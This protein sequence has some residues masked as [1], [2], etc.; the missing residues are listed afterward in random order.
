MDMF[1]VLFAIPR[2]SG[3][4]A[5]GRK[6]STIPIRRSGGHARCA[7]EQG[8]GASCRSNSAG[9]SINMA[10]ALDGEPLHTLT[11][12]RRMSKRHPSA[13]PDHRA[14]LRPRP[15]LD[16]LFD[17]F[18]GHQHPCDRYAAHKPHAARFSGIFTTKGRTDCSILPFMGPAHRLTLLSVVANATSCR[19]SRVSACCSFAD[20]VSSFLRLLVVYGSA[21][22]PRPPRSSG[23]LLIRPGRW[24][25]CPTIP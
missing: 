10:A 16:G 5:H 24:H 6:C 3:W 8:R 23:R 21:P 20:R 19:S 4:L 13:V 11:L 1:P 9:R 2:V 12:S 7:R 15:A 14:T 18:D 22:L 25:A 17:R